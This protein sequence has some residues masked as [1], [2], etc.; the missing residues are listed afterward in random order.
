MPLL[1]LI[2]GWVFGTVFFVAIIV[3]V[4]VAALRTARSLLNI[5]NIFAKTQ[6]YAKI[7]KI[8]NQ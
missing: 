1:S 4:G 2:L 7:I 8:I 6:P 3:G 5:A